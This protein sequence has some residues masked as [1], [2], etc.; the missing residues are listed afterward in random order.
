MQQ[1]WEQR[2]R[3]AY[4]HYAKACGKP[5][6][7][8][9]LPRGIRFVGDG[10][11]VQVSLSAE[12]ATANMQDNAA[13]FEGWCLALRRWC[14]VE[15]VLQ[16]TSPSPATDCFTFWL[17]PVSVFGWSMLTMPTA[18]HICWACHSA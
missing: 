17:Q 15:V 11:K 1:D 5:R 6:R 3:A 4:N 18:V 14:E 8:I 13:A 16:W 9:K 10:K 2:L 7:S 12:G